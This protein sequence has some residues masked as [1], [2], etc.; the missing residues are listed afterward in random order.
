MPDTLRIG[1]IGAGGNTRLRHIPGLKGQPDVELA[2]VC[3]RSMESGQK[4]ASEFGIENVTTNPE[5]VFNDASVNAICIGTWPYKHKD[6]AVW[7]LQSGKHVL[8]EARMA[9]NATEAREM[10][11]ASRAHPERVAQIVPAPFDFR[12]GPT[13][14][15]MLREGYVGQPTDVVINVING[16]GLDPAR[17]LQ[18]RH[19]VDYSGHNIMMMGIYAEVIQRWLGDTTRVTAQAKV[20]VNKR[21]DPES[22]READVGI[23]DSITIAADMANGGRA[24]YVISAVAPVAQ[25]TSIS[26]YGTE[27]VIAWE[28]GD[29]MSTAKLGGQ[30]EP[31]EPEPDL[32]GGWRVEQDFVESVRD[33]KPVSLTNFEDG[34]RYM[35]F[36]DAVWASW[37]EGRAVDV[38]PL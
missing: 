27:G 8:C 5:D 31:R 25:R 33:G 17:T 21:V 36:T 24:S 6:L 30:L 23:P 32:V 29:R 4:V 2:W 37:T 18:W 3:N 22:G 20:V 11:A 10:L 13:I 28:G 16:Q 34:V 26:V 1:F 19:R 7:A 12:C 15:K 38:K 14:A 35:E 9:M